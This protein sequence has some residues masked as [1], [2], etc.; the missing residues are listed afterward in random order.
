M[1]NNQL[2]LGSGFVSKRCTPKQKQH[3]IS[4][5]KRRQKQNGRLPLAY[6]AP[7]N[8]GKDAFLKNQCVFFSKYS[9]SSSCFRTLTVE[10]F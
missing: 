2:Q 6:F 8:F 4:T 10:F 7:S 3:V 1:G 5:W 9:V